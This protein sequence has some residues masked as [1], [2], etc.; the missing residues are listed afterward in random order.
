MPSDSDPRLAA[1]PP[2]WAIEPVGDRCLIV[3]LGEHPG[4]ETSRQVHAVTAL[5]LERALTGVVDVVPAFTS[6]A[7]VFQ[8]MAFSLKRGLPSLQLTRLIDT[9][10]QGGV[11]PLPTDGRLIEVPACY[12]GEFGP[13]LEDVARQC[14]LSPEEVITLHSGVPMTVYAF[15]FSPGNSFA[16]PVDPRLDVR[17]RPTPRTRVEAGTVAI[18]N[19]ITSIYQNTSPGGWNL[20][21]RTPWNMFDIHAAPPT[22]VQLGDRMQFRPISVEEF[23]DTL[24]PRP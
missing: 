15:F 9:A 11:P 18:A 4:I 23:Q 22:R 13:D 7:V 8:P 6:V 10:L 12:G 1:A 19:G 21:A 17:R 5:L 24:E 16:G 3:R 2:F 20:L 14:K